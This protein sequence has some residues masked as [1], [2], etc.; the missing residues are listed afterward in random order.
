MFGFWKCVNLVRFQPPIPQGRCQNEEGNGNIIQARY[1]IG[2]HGRIESERVKPCEKT[3]WRIHAWVM[4][5]N[6]YHL[7]A[8]TPEAK[9]VAG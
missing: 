3:G 5:S 9:L 4:M 8:E 2:V 1:W 6:H 7:L